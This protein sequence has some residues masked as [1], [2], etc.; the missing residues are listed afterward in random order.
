MSGQVKF[1]LDEHVHPAVAD[2]LRRRG[3]DV[4]TAQQANMLGAADKEH[5]ELA[6]QERRVVFTQDDDFLKLHSETTILDCPTSQHS[7]R[8]TTGR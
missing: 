5:L 8:C 4:W 1:Y 6:R 2:G 3:V 7:Y